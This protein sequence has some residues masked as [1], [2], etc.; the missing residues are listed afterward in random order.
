MVVSKGKLKGKMLE[1]F[2]H[3]E[4]TGEPIIVTDHGRE[5]LEIRALKPKTTADEA[6]ARLREMAKLSKP[7]TE[8]ELLEPAEDWTVWGQDEVWLEDK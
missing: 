3:V 7:I 1:Y 4:A 8:E 6:I 5:V 2:R